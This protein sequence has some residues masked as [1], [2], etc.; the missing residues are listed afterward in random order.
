MCVLFWA[1][2]VAALVAIFGILIPKALARP[3]GR[4]MQLL[5][6]KLT[7]GQ[8]IAICMGAVMVLPCTLFLPMQPF[9]WIAGKHGCWGGGGGVQQ[10][11]TRLQVEDHP[12]VAGILLLCQKKMQMTGN[13]LHSQHVEAAKFGCSC[14]CNS[15]SI[16]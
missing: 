5:L 12:L 8:L 3:I 9:I 10:T 4:L 15:S 13:G 11:Q 6:S 1:A 14:S 2:V 16:K 7:Y